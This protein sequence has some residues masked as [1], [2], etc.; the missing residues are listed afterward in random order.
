MKELTTKKVKTR[1][2]YIVEEITKIATEYKEVKKIKMDEG[3]SLNQI[4]Y[5]IQRKKHEQSTARDESPKKIAEITTIEEIRYNGGSRGR[6]Y[7]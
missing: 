2:Y 5:Q 1:L 3:D 7:L 6:T 4:I